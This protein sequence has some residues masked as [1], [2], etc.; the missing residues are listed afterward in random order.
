VLPI[1]VVVSAWDCVME[2]QDAGAFAL[3]M[4]L[5]YVKGLG[6][7]DGRKLLGARQQAPFA[8]RED[9][10]RRTGLDENHQTAL[11]EAGA[12]ARFGDSRREAL[13][14]V[15][16]LSRSAPLSLPV[17]ADP[18]PSFAPLALLETITWDYQRSGHS[19]HG[20]PLGPLRLALQHLGLPDARTV[21]A[22]HHDQHIRYAGIVICRQHPGTAGGVTFMTLEDETGFVNVIIWKRI[23]EL[24]E[25][26]AMTLSFL[27]VTGKLQQQD[28]V[29]HLI[30][31]SLWA[32]AIGVTPA[33]A[34]S[35]DFR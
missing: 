18:L 6:Q 3:R 35:H 11:A 33:Q 34:R 25:H 1:D 32:P 10:V 13:W 28:G 15:Q 17:D 26:Q 19:T 12:L 31:E 20:H 2:P 29:A 22:L 8:S 24:Y 27:G 23:F 14:H 7:A 4:G 21:V 9:F 30:A 5:R 16:G